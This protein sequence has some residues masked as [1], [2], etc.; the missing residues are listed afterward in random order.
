MSQLAIKPVNRATKL[1]G[2]D[3]IAQALADQWVDHLFALMGE[4]T[5]PVISAMVNTQG[6]RHIPTRHESGAVLMAMGYA[7]V[8]DRVGVA[9]VSRGPGLTNALTAIRAAQ[10]DH[11]PLLVIT[12]DRAV[13]AD[14]DGHVITHMKDIVHDDVI[15]TTGAESW[16]LTEIADAPRLIAD[17]YARAAQGVPVVLNLPVD[18]I[19][20]PVEDAP[21]PVMRK[22]PP[23]VISNGR[24]PDAAPSVDKVQIAEIVE[25]IRSAKKP[26]IVAG[27]GAWHSGAET[28]LLELA[29]R[30]GAPTATALLGKGMFD[31]S[32]LHLG[33][34][35]G[36]AT[37]RAVEWATTSDV[38][39]TFG[40][41]LNL[42]TTQDGLLFKQAKVVRV[43][44]KATPPPTPLLDVHTT[45]HGDAKA[46]AEAL[47]EELG[48]EVGAT[49][50]AEL[51]RTLP[52]W[53]PE[54]EIVDQT[55]ADAVHGELLAVRINR[56]LPK[57][58]TLVID[59]GRFCGYSNR[60]FT[61]QDPLDFMFTVW[62]GSMGLGMGSAVGAAFAERNPLTVL[63]VGDAGFMMALSELETAV[64]FKLPLVV[65][66][67]NDGGFGSEVAILDRQGVPFNV[68]QFPTPD[69]DEVARGLGADGAPI[70]SWEDVD[71][72]DWTFAG[73]ER[74]FVI[75][76]RINPL[77]TETPKFFDGAGH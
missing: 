62:F 27:R 24:A 43:E 11:S 45:V 13:A 65:I 74:P 69:L 71:K 60:T 55:T 39:L 53:K 44:L 63:V 58:K 77:A 5:A 22:E 21:E 66:V 14:K 29:E 76:C 18:V 34:V 36:F 64:R 67:F 48:P 1:H 47:L 75:D 72:I 26:L 32:P 49:R 40:A 38:V 46:V 51:R 7:R 30:I 8:T 2:Y 35:G 4:D 15:G 41:S 19:H 33:I 54:D 42:F 9:L 57:E 61:V 6:I 52:A 50:L 3:V 68:A 59:G 37:Q 70:R 28:T 25:L 10:Y 20:T 56:L 23:L 16:R 73:L 12:G 17:A 31:E